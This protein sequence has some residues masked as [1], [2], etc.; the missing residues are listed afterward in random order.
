M[1]IIYCILILLA[2]FRYTNAQIIKQNQLSNFIN[3]ADNIDVLED[4]TCVL[5]IRQI[6]SLKY[7]K[8]FFKSNQSI[9]HFGFT[10]SAYWLR[11]T[12][13]NNS[14]DSLWLQLEHAFIPYADLYFKNTRDRWQVYHAG[15]K[16]PLSN[17]L[18]KDHF[19]TFPLHKGK[20]IYYVRLIPYVHPIPVK[21][22]NSKSYQLT[23]NRER[24]VYGM[25]L[26]IL[27]FAIAIHLFLFITLKF[28]Y[29]LIYCLLIFSYTCSSAGVL[30]GYILYFFPTIDLMYCYKLIPVIDMPILLI[31]CMSFLDVKKINSKLY[32]T[33]NVIC[34]LL[35]VYMVI[36]NFIPALIII[37]I[38]YILALLVFAWACYIGILVGRSGNRLGYYYTFTYT[39]WFVLLFLEELN[40]QFGY[41]SHLFEIT[42]VSIAILIE[43]F[44]LALLLAKRFQWNKQEDENIKFEL[45]TNIFQIQQRFD[46][47]ILQT[48][49]E[50]QEQTFNNISQEIHD[51][52][53]QSLSVINLYLQTIDSPLNKEDTQKITNSINLLSKVVRELRDLAQSLNSD[54]I[55]SVGLSSAVQQQLNLLY[56]T[57]VYQIQFLANEEVEIRDLDKQLLIFR[58]VQELLNNIIKHA[59]ATFIKVTLEYDF[60]KLFIEVYDNGKGF[61]FDKI[62][63]SKQ[64]NGLGLKNISNR[65][66]LINGSFIID[67]QPLNGTKISIS[68][69][70]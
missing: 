13:E 1:K 29:Y 35:L 15:Y 23:R 20:Y 61:D 7:D 40:I 37:F 67:S 62:K 21:L 39:V 25:Y 12:V 5:T 50:I 17:K 36:L 3:I 19:Q 42:Y 4:K 2:N 56:K 16:V 6:S 68:I 49:L 51:N 22:W 63:S 65:L 59:E 9:L 28:S 54:Y 27:F 26:G 48:Q 33:T 46:K 38:N 47:E 70:I 66:N 32:N 69:P 60:A 64:V 31:Y 14:E 18:I 57:A 10:K 30:E 43:A 34:V 55:R 11:F 8:K 53:G 52:I 24:I 44:L 41:P 45:Q 58:I